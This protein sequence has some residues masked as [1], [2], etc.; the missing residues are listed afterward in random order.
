M[1]VLCVFDDAG[2]YVGGAVF[3]YDEDI[4]GWGGPLQGEQVGGFAFY[5]WYKVNIYSERVRLI[6][7]SSYRRIYPDI[8]E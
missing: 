4:A 3:F 8:A 7:R 1:D 2:G 5:L 6:A